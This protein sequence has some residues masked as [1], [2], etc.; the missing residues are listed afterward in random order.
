MSQSCPA[1]CAAASEDLAAIA[2]SHTLAEAMLSGAMT[3][4]GLIRS[5]HEKTFLS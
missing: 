2:V 3:L 4:L 5:F 1:L